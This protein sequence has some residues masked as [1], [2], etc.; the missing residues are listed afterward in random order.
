MSH[1][2]HRQSWTTFKRLLFFLLIIISAI[3]INGCGPI[4]F[5]AGRGFDSGSLESLLSPGVSKGAQVET[6][7]GKPL[8]KGRA[9]MPYHD[10]PRTI[11]TYFFE[12]GSIKLGGGESKDSRKY[13]FV[14]LDKDTYEGY[15]WFDSQL[16]SQTK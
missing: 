3:L 14:F 15:M 1:I 2:K 10:E 8:G 7:L 4:D 11:W 16:I 9:L 6:V 12:K 5:Q 13:L